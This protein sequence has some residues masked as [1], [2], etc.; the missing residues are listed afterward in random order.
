MMFYFSSLGY[1]HVMWEEALS[2]LA[3]VALAATIVECVPVT[4]VVDDNISVPLTTMLV[5]FLLFSFNAQ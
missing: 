5:A 4:E 2:K 1:F 3:L